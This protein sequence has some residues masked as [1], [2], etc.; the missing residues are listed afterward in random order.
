MAKKNP[1]VCPD[2]KIPLNHHAEKED[3]STLEIIEVH[4]CPKCG[5]VETRTAD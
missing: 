5:L 3:Q 1:M 4:T 2:C